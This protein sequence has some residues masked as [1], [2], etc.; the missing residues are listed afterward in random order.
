MKTYTRPPLHGHGLTINQIVDYRDQHLLARHY[1]L[2][3]GKRIQGDVK[4]TGD[5]L[6]ICAEL[7]D[8]ARDHGFYPDRIDEDGNIVWGMEMKSDVQMAVEKFMPDLPALPNEEQIEEM[9]I[10]CRGA[11]RRIAAE[12][13]ETISELQN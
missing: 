3:T 1:R 9:K 7:Y 13:D 12:N 10:A 6:V 11:F 2:Y 4:L 8:R 5:E